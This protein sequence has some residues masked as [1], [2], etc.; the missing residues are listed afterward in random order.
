MLPVLASA[1]GVF[2][3]T[4]I[5]NLLV[6]IALFGSPQPSTGQ[7]IA[8]QYLG[9]SVVVAISVLAAA[10][11]Q[12]RSLTAG[13]TCWESCHSG[14]VSAGSYGDTIETP[15]AVVTSTLGVAAIAVAN[16][17]DNVSVY[18]PVFHEVGRTT[19]VYVATFAVLT[20]VWLT[21][22]RF[23]ATRKPIA[24]LLERWGHWI[25]PCLFVAIGTTLPIGT[26]QN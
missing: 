25:I 22:A 3:A 24:Q 11:A 15:L 16:G 1:V 23:L 6:L 14:S 26:I 18:T 8:G 19:V 17:A 13:S 10:R 7:I 9:M 21:G 20:A 12:R 5:D 2:V 4:N